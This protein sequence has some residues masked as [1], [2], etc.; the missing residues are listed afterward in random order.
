MMSRLE[1]DRC[2]GC[3]ESHKEDDR[4]SN[5]PDEDCSEI[6]SCPN[7]VGSE[8]GCGGKIDRAKQ[9]QQTSGKFLVERA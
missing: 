3:T 4:P 9:H 5:V 8:Q 6:V 2:G 7:A 1:E